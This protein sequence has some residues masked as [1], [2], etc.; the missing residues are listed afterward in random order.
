[1]KIYF[2][3]RISSNKIVIIYIGVTNN[4]A[5]RVWEHKNIIVQGFSSQYNIDKLVHYEQYSE[6]V[7][8]IKRENDLKI[9]S[10]NRTLI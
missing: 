5:R 1:M 4:L 2:I 3:Y 10:V 8:A 9:R 6:I 7:Y